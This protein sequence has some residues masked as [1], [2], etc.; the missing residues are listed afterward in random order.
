M[1]TSLL[2][3]SVPHPYT[4]DN[5][6]AMR[7]FNRWTGI[8][9]VI[10]T[11]IRLNEYYDHHQSV[12]TKIVEWICVAQVEAVVAALRQDNDSLVWDRVVVLAFLMTVEFPMYKDV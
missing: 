9:S 3:G 8:C 7:N 4:D 5:G 2:L 1:P 11:W 6:G 12:L 10:V